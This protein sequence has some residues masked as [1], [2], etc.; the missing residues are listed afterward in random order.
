MNSKRR[1]QIRDRIITPTA[2][3]VYNSLLMSNY[4]PMVKEYHDEL[5]PIFSTH[6]LKSEISDS[7]IDT[8]I[9]NKKEGYDQMVKQNL[10]CKMVNQRP[11]IHQEY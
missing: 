6:E 2:D 4:F 1:S 5:P 8:S 3:E 9:L 7:L 11:L 10:F